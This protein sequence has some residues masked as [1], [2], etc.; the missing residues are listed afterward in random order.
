M[1][2]FDQI[3]KH[4]G[5]RLGVVMK[6][7]QKGW[8]WAEGIPRE[9]TKVNTSM[10]WSNTNIGSAGQQYSLQEGMQILQDLVLH[11][12]TDPLPIP[13]SR[14][15]FRLKPRPATSHT[16]A[17]PQ[18]QQVSSQSQ[19]AVP[20]LHQQHQTSHMRHTEASSQQLQSHNHRHS[21]P[22]T[23][24]STV[25]PDSNFELPPNTYQGYYL[26]PNL[27]TAASDMQFGDSNLGNLDASQASMQNLNNEFSY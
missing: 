2:I 3:L 9:T 24:S 23:T 20:R 16:Q 27:N 13:P 17:T 10:D 1:Q 25:P 12:E 15:P 6:A 14:Q 26:A 22:N 4:T 8:G 18:T 21:V 19:L 11:A 5:W 7:I